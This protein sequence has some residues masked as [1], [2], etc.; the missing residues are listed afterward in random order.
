MSIGYRPEIDGLRAVAV[1]AVI[2]YHANLLVYGINFFKG[3]FIGVDVFFVI[4]GYLIS[5]I[6]LSELKERRFSF[7]RF[8]DRRARR[9]LPAL[10]TV[11]AVSIPFALY[12][13]S[14]KAIKEYSGSVL[15]SLAFGSNIWFLYEDSYT[16]ESSLLKPFLHTWSLSVEEQFY[17]IFPI[18]LLLLWKYEKQYF[19]SIFILVFLVSLQ[20]ADIGSVR[21]SDATFFLLPTRGWELLAGAILARIEIDYGR[22]SHRLLDTIMPA[23]G[24]FFICYAI[25][26]FDDN[27]RHPS[28]ITLLPVLGTMMLI[29]F[30]KKGELVSDILSS[31]QMVAIGLM[32]YSLY[33]WHYPIFAFARIKLGS[34]S[35]IEILL[36]IVLTIALSVVS[37]HFI[38]KPARKR[39]F[40]SKPRFYKILVTF[41]VL[42]ISIISYSYYYANN[43]IQKFSLNN[44]TV[45]IEAEKWKRFSYRNAIC[46]ELGQDMCDLPQS[47]L[48]NILVVGDSMAD[49]AV[50]VI[51]NVF[52]SYHFARSSLGGC[53]P[54]PEFEKLAGS[55]LPNLRECLSLNKIRFSNDSL[56]GFDGVVI[57]T[58]YSW[59]TPD[60]LKTYLTFLKKNNFKNV[61]IFG[62]YISLRENMDDILRE[63][64]GDEFS[65]NML[66]SK[67][68]ILHQFNY[69]EEL[70][71]L[72]KEFGFTYISFKDAACRNRACPV[73][74]GIYPFTWDKY[75]FSYEFSTYMSEKLKSKLLST[76]LNNL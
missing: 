70:K 71:Q 7:S 4:S 40:I 34:L 50:N 54:Y 35:N 30:C 68:L 6:I 3:G 59:Y 75:H 76:W 31:K 28:F 49:D 24:L 72:S 32:S 62:N 25:V 11:M 37:Y 8:Y 56:K 69:E 58:L 19:L 44:K 20:I 9:I 43:Q 27:M 22:I 52:P 18:L 42:L 66:K 2:L 14:F 21:F 61:I 64:E 45:D 36:S 57:N 5:Y 1:T 39:G 13:M 60:H 23:I 65:Y 73:V 63:L 47:G 33:L 46:K 10:F 41:A 74:T 48:K 51:A 15:S 67:E 38:E 53:P 29:W 17:F 12:L 26:F 55:K 16:A